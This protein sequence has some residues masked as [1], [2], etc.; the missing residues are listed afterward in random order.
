MPHSVAAHLR[1]LVALA[2]PVTAAQLGSMMLL[3]VDLLMLGRVGV[4]ALDA[5]SLGRVW[6]MGT[7]V[8]GMGLAFGIDPVATQA[9]GA[10]D[11]E[12]LVGALGNGLV[13]ALFASLPIALLWSGTGPVLGLLG[14]SPELSH[15]A[16]V[17]VITQI[18]GLPFFLLFTVLKQH[19]QA[20]GIVQPAMWVTFAANGFNA[21]A[22]WVLIFGHWGAPALGV[23]GAGI[24]TSLTHVVLVL[25]LVGWMHRQGL[26][27]RSWREV[28]RRGLERRGIAELARFG[29]PVALQI[30]LEMWAF[31]I[32]TLW[33]G[34]LGEI[35]LAAH[36]VAL[37]LA[38]VTFMVPLG[39]SLAAV[40]RVGNLMGA[41]EHRD[42]QRA[43][44]V[45]VGL[46]AVVMAGSAL[47][48][49][50]GRNLLPRAF[51][52]D[53]EV[54]AAA[55]VILPIAAAFQ[56]F[57]GTQVVGAGVLRG[58]GQTRPAAAFNVVGYYAL[59]LP[60][61]WWL[62]FPRG[63]GLTGIWWGLALG[64]ATVALLLVA[65]IARFGPGRRGIMAR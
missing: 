36:T 47:L 52:P 55:A 53:P 25:G 64:L 34:R 32:A 5:A 35:P 16:H 37:T 41:R 18:P 6:V 22:N 30:G 3:V 17:Y 38:S 60:L 8:F 26:P 4:E 62:A 44:W 33:A 61:A 49:V 39:V 2:L 63:M 45:A 13:L 12:R 31:Q 19:L 7:I 42:A 29:S 9:F 50:L 57:D 15:Q 1:R 14:Q 21:V 10:G 11:D 65:Y 56:V 28:W 54:I 43:A 59:A 58:M 48:F 51:T 40:V 24:A 27:R 23:A 20:Q 46:G